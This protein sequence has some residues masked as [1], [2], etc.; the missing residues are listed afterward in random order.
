MQ[1]SRMRGL[2]IPMPI[3]PQKTALLFPGQGS[4]TL[5]M[6]SVLVKEEP[7][8]AHVFEQADALL[9]YSLS[10]LCWHG[11]VEK[12]NETLHTQPALLTHG[13][14]VLDVFRARFPGF[15]PAAVAGHSLGQFTALVASGALDF[16]GALRLVRA[17]AEAMQFAG[18]VSPGG[19]AAVLGLGIEPVEQAC[20]LAS[21]AGNGVWIA[22]DNCPGQVVISGHEA[23]LD[24][25]S[26]LLQE[27]GARK[28]VR[29]AVSIAAHSPL[30][31]AAQARFNLALAEARIEAPRVSIIGNVHAS[32]LSHP[33]DI[34]ADLSA[35]LSSRVRWTESVERMLAAGLDTFIEM[36]PGNVLTGLLRRI[37]RSAV[38]YNLDEPASFAAISEAGAA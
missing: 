36:G 29:L 9:G 5:G 15:Q 34:R 21:L 8:A 4:Q 11:P 27:A 16:E 2:T 24:Y 26:P 28:V 38:G 23:G 35:Q 20:R 22:N 30:M 13:V 14:A 1:T 25:V 17:R 31:E 18:E 37:N 10:E 3:Q 32:E 12:L 19:M 6:G 7:L 33:D